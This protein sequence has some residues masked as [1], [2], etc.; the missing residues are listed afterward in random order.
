MYIRVLDTI[1]SS[2]ASSEISWSGSQL[3]LQGD[4][5]K[6]L[7]L[8]INPAMRSTFLGMRSDDKAQL[9]SVSSAC[10]SR[11]TSRVTTANRKL[12][13]SPH[14]NTPVTLSTGPTIRQLG[15]S[16]RSP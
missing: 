14:I 13:E 6:Q 5:R 3:F 15:W 2:A 16:T 11:S 12:A 8:K 9:T 7:F 1:P 10:S 4:R